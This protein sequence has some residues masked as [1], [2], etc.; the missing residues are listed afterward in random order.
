MSHERNWLCR[1]WYVNIKFKKIVF[2]FSFLFAWPFCV[3]AKWNGLVYSF[4]E[5]ISLW[6]RPYPFYHHASSHQDLEPTFSWLIQNEKI[7]FVFYDKQ[8]K[9]F[10]N[11]GYIIISFCSFFFLSQWIRRCC[12]RIWIR[13]QSQKRFLL[14]LAVGLF[15]RIK[16]WI[17]VWSFRHTYSVF[18]KEELRRF[19]YVL[20]VLFLFCLNTCNV[21]CHRHIQCLIYTRSNHCKLLSCENLVDKFIFC[22]SVFCRC[23]HCYEQEFNWLKYIS[24]SLRHY[25]CC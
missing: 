24:I 1:S 18:N 16:Y 5:F 20:F 15:K 3:C 10:S 8:F 9:T 4:L 2:F 13:I 6:T 7:H 19:W 22:L 14:L 17:V 11:V 12:I 23:Q 21:R 25:L